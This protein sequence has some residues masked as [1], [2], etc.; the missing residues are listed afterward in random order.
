MHGVSEL[1]WTQIVDMM[2]DDVERAGAGVPQEL[3]IPLLLE[4]A[5]RS[6]QQRLSSRTSVQL[7]QNSFERDQIFGVL[8]GA[9]T[10][11]HTLPAQLIA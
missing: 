9:D 3:R 2:R 6:H 10:R 5:A 7:F 8:L 11:T 1:T 4:E